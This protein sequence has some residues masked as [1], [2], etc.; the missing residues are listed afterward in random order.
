MPIPVEGQQ[1]RQTA[2]CLVVCL[3]CLA[4]SATRSI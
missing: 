3:P 4:F 2:V 1:T